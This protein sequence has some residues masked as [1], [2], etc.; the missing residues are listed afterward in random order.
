[1]SFH[2]FIIA[3]FFSFFYLTKLQHAV[4]IGSQLFTVFFFLFYLLFCKQSCL[5]N[6]RINTKID[7][8]KA[9]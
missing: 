4:S 2:L 7:K 6:G 1:M 5:K 9:F 3:K 8:I